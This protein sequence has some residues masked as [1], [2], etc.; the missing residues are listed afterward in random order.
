MKK[1]E[2]V[3]IDI[4][5]QKQ[6]GSHHFS[7]IYH[8]TDSE[9]GEVIEETIP[10]IEI[11]LPIE[12]SEIP[13]VRH[14]EIRCA[15]IDKILYK[16]LNCIDFHSFKTTCDDVEI[17]II[18]PENKKEMTVDEIEKELGYKIKVVGDKSKES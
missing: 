4:D 6:N 2:L 10:N 15:I 5:K 1:I 14:N 18:T 7:L 3:K 17:K 9:T 11:K 13:E 12:V 16:W 8:I